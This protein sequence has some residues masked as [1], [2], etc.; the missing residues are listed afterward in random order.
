M[1]THVDM[2]SAE[3]KKG[4]MDLLLLNIYIFWIYARPQDCFHFLNIFHIPKLVL[5][6]LVIK[7]MFKGRLFSLKSM[8]STDKRFIAFFII[9]VLSLI[10][11]IWKGRTLEMI[12]DFASIFLSYFVIVALLDKESKVLGFL[13]SLVAGYLLISIVQIYVFLFVGVNRVT[14]LGGYG[15]NFGA[16]A[17]GTGSSYGVGS[18]ANGFLANASDLGVGMLV[19]IPLTYYAMKASTT[20]MTRLYFLGSLVLFSISVVFSGSRGA[21]VGAAAMVFTLIWKSKAKAKLISLFVVL[22]LLSLPFIPARYFDRISSISNFKEDESVQIRMELWGAGWQMF[23]DSPILGVGAGNFRTA[24]GLEYHSYTEGGVQWWNPHSIYVH[25]LAELGFVGIVTYIFFITSVMRS[26]L[27]T[28]M[29]DPPLE[30]DSG[31]LFKLSNALKISLVSFL[32]SGA[33]ITV[34]YFPH[35]FYL[36]ALTS[37]NRKC[38]RKLPVETNKRISRENNSL[39]R[40]NTG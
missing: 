33:F 12:T 22:A 20:K 14:G 35:L 29:K 37:V 27:S 21:F 39:K 40:W 30:R 25:V 6:Y 9:M 8:Y 23:L 31:D 24:Y 4:S 3:D 18:Y 15:L 7:L 5:L 17:S 36:A 28:G 2:K 38:Y 34:T 13:K 26:K 11:S 32:V 19:M 10:P 1:A 16:A